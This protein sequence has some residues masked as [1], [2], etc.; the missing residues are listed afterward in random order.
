MPKQ[1]MSSRPGLFTKAWGSHPT[2]QSTVLLLQLPAS[3]HDR[4]SRSAQQNLQGFATL[5]ATKPYLGI[6]NAL[7]QWKREPLTHPPP[8]PNMLSLYGCGKQ[9]ALLPRT[10]GC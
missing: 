7:A 6:P 4:Q 9:Q 8:P 5:L 1:S 10:A 2:R 3:A